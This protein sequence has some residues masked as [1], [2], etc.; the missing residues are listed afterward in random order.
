MFSS[1]EG[2]RRACLLDTSGWISGTRRAAADAASQVQV[3][4]ARRGTALRPRTM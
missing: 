2:V 4:R 3:P 1:R